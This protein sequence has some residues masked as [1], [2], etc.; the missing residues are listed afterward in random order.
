MENSYFIKPSRTGEWPWLIN[1]PRAKSHSPPVTG[2]CNSRALPPPPPPL[3]LWHQNTEKITRKWFLFSTIY[4]EPYPPSQHIILHS[5]LPNFG[6]FHRTLQRVRLANWG[7]LLL[8]T[9]GPVPFGTCICSSVGTVLSWTCLVYG[10][11][12]FRTSLGTSILLHSKN[13]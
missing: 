9:P 10:P 8:P 2:E 5:K 3:F 1:S 12:E 13:H 7:R 4:K 6:G 11:F